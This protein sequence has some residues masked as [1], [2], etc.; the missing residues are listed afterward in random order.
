[1]PSLCIKNLTKRY[2]ENVVLND[3]SLATT[4]LVLLASSENHG[5][6]VLRPSM[7]CLCPR[8]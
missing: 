4:T 7:S 5:R 1:M 2:G 3:L 8:G 6:Y